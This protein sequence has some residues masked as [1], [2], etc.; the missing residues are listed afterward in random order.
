LNLKQARLIQIVDAESSHLADLIDDLLVLAKLEAK[1]VEMKR[2]FGD[3]A[4]IV[5]ACT[6]S[7]KT[8]AEQKGLK[9]EQVVPPSL[10]RILVDRTQIQKVFYNLLGNAIKFT[11]AGG[12]ITVVIRPVYNDL[13]D[14]QSPASLNHI[15]VDVNDTGIGIPKPDL[16]RI[17][18]KFHRVDSTLTAGTP[19]T[20]LGLSICREI[21]EAHGGRIWVESEVGKGSQFHFALPPGKHFQR[22]QA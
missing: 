1:K 6:E 14:A 7:L 21:I 19:G 4:E 9:M 18:E 17:F 12:E 22:S 10:P 13:P 15:E 5:A 20:G 8:V 3:L 11:P 2:E 16:S